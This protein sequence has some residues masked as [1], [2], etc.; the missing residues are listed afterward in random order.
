MDRTSKLKRGLRNN[1]LHIRT[2]MWAA[3]Q[4][5]GERH[6]HAEPA[7]WR[8]FIGKENYMLRAN[9][10]CTACQWDMQGG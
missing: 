8:M 2:E 1:G 5:S 3:T 6:E 4:C 10:A 7:R 9:S